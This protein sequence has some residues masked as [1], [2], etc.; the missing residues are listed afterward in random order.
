MKQPKLL[1]AL[2]T[3]ALLWGFA[4]PAAIVAQ[5]KGMWRAANKTAS[6]ITGDVAFSDI[7]IAINFSSFTIANIRNLTPAELSAAFDADPAAAGTGTLYRLDIPGTKKFLHGNTL[8]G[9]EDTQWIATYVSGRDLQLAFFSGSNMPVFT[10]EV[11][12]NSTDLCGLYS[13]MR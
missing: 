2:V 11:L 5:E 3:S 6:S 1:C 10:P 9:A 8:C 12:S 13:Y 7:K 4:C